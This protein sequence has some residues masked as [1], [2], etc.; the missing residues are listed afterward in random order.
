MQSTLHAEHSGQGDQVGLDV[1]AICCRSQ[2]GLHI[3]SASRLDPQ[4]C[5]CVAG[6]GSKRLHVKLAACQPWQECFDGPVAIL[7][8][9]S[10]SEMFVMQPIAG[11]A[12]KKRGSSLR[13]LQYS[14]IN[15]L[16]ARSCQ[17]CH[18]TA[19]SPT[20]FLQSLIANKF[21]GTICW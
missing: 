3:D 16:L 20:N 8:F 4:L 10:G 2:G 17:A 21:S 18:Q 11:T 13:P 5:T 15:S 14:S 6:R 12:V 1:Q 9:G 19:V 7:S